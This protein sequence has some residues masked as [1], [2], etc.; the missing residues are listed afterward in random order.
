MLK[1]RLIPT[2]LCIKGN[3]IVQSIN[4]KH[5]N[6]VGNAI[7]AIDF[8]NNWA[9]DEIIILDVS[10]TE[11]YR[12]KFH[13]IIEGLSKRCFVPLTVGGW[14]KDTSEIQRFLKEG[15]DKISINSQAYLNPELIKESS[16]TFGSQSIVVSI[17]VKKNS[18]GKHDVVIDR[19]RT[20]TGIDVVD[21]AKKAEELGAGEIFLTSIDNDGAKEGYDLDLI[22]KISSIISIPVVAF[23]GVG[24]W[25]HFV[26]GILKGKA[27]AVSAGNI[28]HYTEQSTYEAKK[29][30]VNSGLNVRIPTFYKIPSQRNP[31]YTHEG[32]AGHF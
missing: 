1:N 17:D 11:E 23:G 14:I 24:K 20:N 15:A 30:M 8:Y 9:V 25:E 3:N 31:K 12:E 28:F 21:W 13:K 10:R 32:S 2:L 6:I 26:D 5:T 27:D 18:Q 29:F 4:F 19:G 7:T 16:K 22:K